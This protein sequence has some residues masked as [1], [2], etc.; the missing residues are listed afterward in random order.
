[1]LHYL[2]LGWSVIPNCHPSHIGYGAEHTKECKNGHNEGK[3][4]WC[5]WTEHQETL[6]SETTVQDWWR[7]HPSSNVGIALGQIS[8]LVRVDVD[9]AAGEAA[10]Q[11]IGGGD[12]PLTLEFRS[13]RVDG[14]GRGLLYRIPDGVAL[15]TTR[16]SHGEKSE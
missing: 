16:N 4:P 12:L 10:L 9:G 5:Y 15:R 8:R 2:S 14:T 11:K 3:R 7:Q 13:G 6:P 1:A